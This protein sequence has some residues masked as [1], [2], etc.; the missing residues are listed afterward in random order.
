MLLFI[1]QDRSYVMIILYFAAIHL[2]VLSWNM[3]TITVIWKHANSQILD[4]Q[5]EHVCCQQWDAIK[6]TIQNENKVLWNN[7]TKYN[8]AT[9]LYP[10]RICYFERLLICMLLYF[11]MT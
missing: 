8:A 10:P 11:K 3:K 1:I 5:F 6:T 7:A 4:F 9:H 2:I